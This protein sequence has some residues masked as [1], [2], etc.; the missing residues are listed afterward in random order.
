M[1]TLVVVGKESAAKSEAVLINEEGQGGR[2]LGAYLMGES[3]ERDGSGGRSVCCNDG[4][5]IPIRWLEP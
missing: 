5:L 1:N 3:D 4:K 2:E